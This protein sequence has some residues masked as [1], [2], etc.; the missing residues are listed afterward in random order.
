M[1]S[2]HCRKKFLGAFPSPTPLGQST[3]ESKSQIAAYMLQRIVGTS[4]CVNSP[5]EVLQVWLNPSSTHWVK[6]LAVKTLSTKSRSWDTQKRNLLSFFLLCV[7]SYPHI[8]SLCTVSEVNLWRRQCP[9][10][11]QAPS[12][13]PSAWSNRTGEG[14]CFGFVNK[15]TTPLTSDL[16]VENVS[17]IR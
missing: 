9:T 13:G 15:I 5:A 1:I 17:Y 3:A 6:R 7:A 2:S 4:A 10:Q 12:T 11:R 16:G 8:S 14:Q